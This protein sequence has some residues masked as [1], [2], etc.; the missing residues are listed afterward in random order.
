M[1]NLSRL[2]LVSAL[3]AGISSLS[4]SA[5]LYYVDLTPTNGVPTGEGDSDPENFDIGTG[6]TVGSTDLVVTEL[7]AWGGGGSTSVQGLTVYTPALVLPLST[8][9]YIWNSSGQ[10]VAE[11]QIAAGTVATSASTVTGQGWAFAGLVN[12]TTGAAET[13][14]TLQAGDTYYITNDTYTAASK[15]PGLGYTRLPL[16]D[17]TVGTGVVGSSIFSEYSTDDS[18]PTGAAGLPLTF[19]GNFIYTVLPEPTTWAMLLVGF[20]MLAFVVRRRAAKA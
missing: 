1:K 8:T 15:T 19:G 20:G 5:Q 4:A 14:V 10:I 16:A 17:L 2:V 13:S 11:A 6:F 7:G 18:F 12:P 9:A 3:F